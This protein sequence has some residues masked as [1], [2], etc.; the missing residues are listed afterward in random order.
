MEVLLEL[1][2]ASPPGIFKGAHEGPSAAKPQPKIR[3]ISRKD[4]K[5]AKKIVIRTCRSSRLGGKNSESESPISEKFPRAAKTLKHEE[6]PIG[7]DSDRI[8]T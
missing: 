3:N 6:W 4:A 1:T 5:A 8:S 2:E 7:L